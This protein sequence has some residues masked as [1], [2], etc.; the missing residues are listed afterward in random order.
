MIFATIRGPKN[1]GPPACSDL[2][3]SRRFEGHTS[4]L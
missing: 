3:S 2:S 1:Q 4:E